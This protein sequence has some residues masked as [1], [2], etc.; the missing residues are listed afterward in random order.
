[1]RPIKNYLQE[2]AQRSRTNIVESLGESTGED[3][4]TWTWRR[5]SLGRTNN[6]SYDRCSDDPVMEWS[7]RF[8]RAESWERMR[9]GATTS[10]H[11]INSDARTINEPCCTICRDVIG[12]SELQTRCCGQPSFC[13]NCLGICINFSIQYLESI[14]SRGKYTLKTMFDFCFESGYVCFKHVFI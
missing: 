4:Y 3:M 6:S 2:L 9:H 1:M 7:M 10:T 5:S 14:H 11:R 12:N 13:E 8:H